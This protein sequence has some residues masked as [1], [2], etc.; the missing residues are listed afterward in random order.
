MLL[1]VR[2]LQN[3][4]TLRL[5]YVTTGYMRLQQTADGSSK[6]LQTMQGYN[7]LQQLYGLQYVTAGYV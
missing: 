1:Q 6:L 7:M 3:V 4:M 2:M 5:H